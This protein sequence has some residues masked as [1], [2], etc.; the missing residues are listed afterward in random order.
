MTSPS[1]DPD[2]AD[3]PGLEGGTG[4]NPGDTPPSEAGMSGLSENSTHGHKQ[5]SGAL[6]KAIPIGIIALVLLFVLFLAV[7]PFLLG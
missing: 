7:R 6:N 3:T 2:P 1:A 5:P 4:V